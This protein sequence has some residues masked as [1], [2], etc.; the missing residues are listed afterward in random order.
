MADGWQL[1]GHLLF[2]TP[3]NELL[4][5]VY[6]ESSAYSP[7]D[8]SVNVFVQP[9]YVPATSPVFSFGYRQKTG[10]NREWWHFEETDIT[11][12]GWELAQAINTAERDFFPQV[13]TAADFHRRYRPQQRTAASY[14]EA[15][16]YSACYAGLEKKAEEVKGLLHFLQTSKEVN[17]EWEWVQQ[18]YQKTQQL[19]LLLTQSEPVRPLLEHWRVETMR[20]LRLA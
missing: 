16:V 12:V 2:A 17:L 4:K 5:G 20:H 18:M 9:L 7:A 19:Q 11:Q 1:K 13:A 3:V 8:F 10:A 6:L 15:V 14:Y